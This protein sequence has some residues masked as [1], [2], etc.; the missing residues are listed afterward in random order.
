[1]LLKLSGFFIN[2]QG[3]GW[4]CLP[5]VVVVDRRGID[6]EGVEHLVDRLAYKSLI[7]NHIDDGIDV[8]DIDFTVLI[9]IESQVKCTRIV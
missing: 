6:A 8:C 2:P 4:G 3:I 5:E 9:Y 7:T 1:M